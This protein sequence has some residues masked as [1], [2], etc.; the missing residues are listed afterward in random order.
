[1]DLQLHSLIMVCR[2]STNLIA[3]ISFSFRNQVDMEMAGS[4]VHS[5]FRLS[6]FSQ[7]ERIVIQKLHGRRR[8]NAGELIGLGHT[9][10][11]YLQIR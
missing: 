2:N 1:M 7:G 5:S 6:P 3:F 8:T 10:K 4:N 9:R 11:C